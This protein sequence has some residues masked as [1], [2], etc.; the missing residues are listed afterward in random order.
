MY[1]KYTKNAEGRSAPQNGIHKLLLIMRLIVIISIAMIMQVRAASFGQSV[2]LNIKNAPLS[3]IIEEI[4]TQTGY[5]FFYNRELIKK[6]RPVTIDVTNASIQEV[7]ELCFSDQ[8]LD[9]KIDNKVVM[10]R[11]K[12]PDLLDRVIDL[13]T[14]PID[15]RGHVRDSTGAPLPGATVHLKNNNTGTVT[16]TNGEFRLSNIEEGAVLEISYIGFVTQELVVTRD[17]AQSI[18]I[19][20]KESKSVLQELVVF[21]TGYQTISKERSTGSFAQADMDVVS[22]R[23]TSMNILSRLDGLIPGLAVNNYAPGRDQLLIRGA[24]SIGMPVNSYFVGTSRTPLF[25]VDGVAVSDVSFINPQD[26]KDVT[27]L[28]DATAASIWGARAANGVI[29]INTKKGTLNSNLR[30]NYDGFINFQG[31]PQLDYLPLLS[32]R[33]YIESAKELFSIPDYLTVYPWAT[34]SSFTGPASGGVP[35]HEMILYNQARGLVTEAQAN[36]SLDS[37]AAI[38]NH[39]QI[40]DLFY[41]NAV[42]M[43]YTVSLS[44]GGSH[45]SFYASASYTD[46]KSNQP[47]EANKVYKI[48]ARQDFKL[49]KTFQFFLVTDITQ[50][51][52]SAKRNKSFDYS[53]YPY[54]LFR[55]ESGNNLS[56]PYMYLPDGPRADF[57]ARSRISLDY[58]PLD[59][60][61]YGYTKTDGLVARFTGGGTINIF[62]GLRFEGTYNYIKGTTKSIEFE[63]Q[64]SYTVRSELVSFTVAPTAAST[65]VYYLPSTGGR[66]TVTTSDLKNWTVRNQLVYDNKWD[67]HQLTILL[68]QEAQDQLN[69]THASRV[70][71]YDEALQIYS[72]VDYAAL[73]KGLASP[74][75]PNYGGVLSV[76]SNDN[77]SSSETESRFTSYYSNLGYTY[78]QKY[79]VNGSWRIDQSTLFGKDKSAQNKPVWSA[80]AKWLIT[81]E[82]FM[83]N[84]SWLESLALRATYGLTGNSPSPGTASSFD[85]LSTSGSVF[86]PGGKGLK[87]STTGNPKL[88]WETTQTT[89][90]AV[91]FALLRGRINGSVDFYKKYTKNM[92]GLVNTNSLTGYPSVVGNLGDMTNKGVEI[93]LHT[94]N[95]RTENFSWNTSLVAGYNE[96]KIIKHLSATPITT[97]SQ[98]IPHAGGQFLEGYPAFSMF[99]YDFVGLDNQGD[100]QI[101]LNDGTITK[102]PGVALAKDVKYMGTILPK[103]TGGFSNMFRYKNFQLSANAVYSLGYIMRRSTR[104]MFGGQLRTNVSKDFLKRWKTE[105]DEAHTNIPSYEVSAATSLG[106]RSLDYFT[107]GD[108][109]VLSASY[110]KLR[111]ITFSYYLPEAI[112]SKVRA[113]SISFRA[114]LSNVM[115]WKAN[116]YGID[117]EF[118][119]IMP[120]NQKTITLGAHITL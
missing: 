109:N 74:V 21:S 82:E 114:Q 102:T 16:D 100:P 118:Q 40:S 48:N 120:L 50:T 38:N 22:E 32:S 92:L 117:P 20:L 98:K 67:I 33:Q 45:H 51:R 96:N 103:W 52:T 23:S 99:A 110:I 30:V 81:N 53:F 58:N 15:V 39:D 27:V 12:E 77:F 87:I 6:A 101:R 49:N 61:N 25:V 2:T 71:G 104:W 4:R 73:G 113:Q 35:P 111:D 56:I 85:I 83:N 106:R 107:Y 55:D 91:D 79:S 26:V 41:R 63:D 7:L 70:R 59:E 64:K 37:L 69:V 5:D 13:L 108:V 84:I 24:T 17:N 1:K 89:N 47:G 60:F 31:R 34:V 36:A 72:S 3:E 46:T 57:Q 65:P 95:M 28:K 44:G 42:L 14:P 80:G 86:Y 43:N 18:S 66:Y 90:L 116:K 29:V 94:T 78:N 88:T 97:A 19:V 54:Q 119:S 68:G 75:M 105:G 93:S 10:I 62:K 115:L 112:V 9:Y 11:E 8:P 76:L